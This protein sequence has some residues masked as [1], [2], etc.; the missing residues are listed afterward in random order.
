VP[1]AIHPGAVIHGWDHFV[2]TLRD[3][4]GRRSAFLTLYA[5]TYSA[6]LGAGN[7]AFLRVD[8]PAVDLDVAL[9]DAPEVAARMQERLGRMGQTDVDRDR[10]PIEAL[11]TRHRAG[12]DGFGFSISWQAHTMEARWIDPTLPFW[13]IAP[14]PDLKAD[15]DIWALF[16]EA[17][18]ASLTVDGR[19]IAGEPFPDD[20]WVAKVGRSLSSAHVALS[21][22]RVTPVSRESGDGVAEE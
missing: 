13:M 8:D 17:P 22:V 16:V 1:A 2:I 4:A 19:P 14:A 10:P 11:F 21:E 6:T 15:E 20:V 7:V 12:P 9:T 5:I 18:R 3:A